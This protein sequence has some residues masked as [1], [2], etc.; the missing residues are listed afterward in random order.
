MLHWDKCAALYGNRPTRKSYGDL[1]RSL[2]LAR[3]AA[4]IPEMKEAKKTLYH[5]LRVISQRR[6]SI[7][8]TISQC[9]TRPSWRYRSTN[10]YATPKPHRIDSTSAATTQRL[11][12]TPGVLPG[13][14]HTSAAHGRRGVVFMYAPGG[15]L[16]GP[17]SSHLRP[18]VPRP[19]AGGTGSPLTR[20]PCPQCIASHTPSSINKITSPPPST[21]TILVILARKQNPPH[22]KCFSRSY[23]KSTLFLSSISCSFPVMIVKKKWQTLPSDMTYRRVGKKII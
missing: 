21:T 13:A 5:T 9:T 17:S 16:G 6:E 3:P 22:T 14:H 7:F 23:Y 10:Q 12:T 20:L 15:Y 2:I 8:H 19:H 1:D 18:I 4:Y 11:R